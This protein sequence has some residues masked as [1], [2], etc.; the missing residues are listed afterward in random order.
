M[1]WYVIRYSYVL[2]CLVVLKG[3]TGYRDREE[4][5]KNAGGEAAGIALLPEIGEIGTHVTSLSYDP[6]VGRGREV[7]KNQNQERV[8]IYVG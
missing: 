6:F 3:Q 4:A 7:P 2:F 5:A 1:L 8:P